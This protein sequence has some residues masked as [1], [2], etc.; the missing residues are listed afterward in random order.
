[1]QLLIVELSAGLPG[2]TKLLQLMPSTRIIMCVEALYG[3]SECSQAGVASPHLE[4]SSDRHNHSIKIRT[5]NQRS[6]NSVFV[7]V[8]IAL[9]DHIARPLRVPLHLSDVLAVITIQ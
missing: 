9:R 2:K 5:R 4:L 3:A 8:K 7:V 6:D 1:M